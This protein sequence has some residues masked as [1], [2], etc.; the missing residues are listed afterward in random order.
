M[1]LLHLLC[2]ERMAA[3]R[4]LDFSIKPVRDALMVVAMRRMARQGCHELS[5]SILS[6]ANDA[7]LNARKPDVTV[8]NLGRIV[9]NAT[10]ELSKFIIGLSF[11]VE[12]PADARTTKNGN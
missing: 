5:L 4:T 7:V 3:L 10:F 9:Q 2:S 11:V 6:L 12:D 8:W 1:V